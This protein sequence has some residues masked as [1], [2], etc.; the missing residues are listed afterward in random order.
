[1]L[2]FFANLVLGQL[3]PNSQVQKDDLLAAFTDGITESEDA[4]QEQFGDDRLIAPLK[5]NSRR[6]LDE[7]LQLVL[8]TVSNW[9]HDPSARDDITM[10]L[11]R[12]R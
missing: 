5:A 7:I 8:E 4:Q 6:P 11:A 9:A 2:R 1:L 12:K 3:L 10:L